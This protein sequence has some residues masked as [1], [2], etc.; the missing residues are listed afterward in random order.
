M[1]LVSVRELLGLL[2]PPMEA[3]GDRDPEGDLVWLCA[4]DSVGRRL[5]VAVLRTDLDCWPEAETEGLRELDLDWEPEPERDRVF[6]P[7]G[8][9]VT[10]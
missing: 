7:V 1:D 9:M 2:V 3:E 10:V 8:E 6:S 5:V 4:A